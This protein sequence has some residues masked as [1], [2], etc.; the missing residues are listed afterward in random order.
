MTEDT[1]LNSAALAWVEALTARG[2]RLTAHRKGV[3]FDP[4]SAYREMSNEERA[5][6]KAHKHE[7]IALVRA[8]VATRAAG[9]PVQAAAPTPS[10]GAAPTLALAP[11]A[12]CEYCG[13]LASRCAEIRGDVKFLTEH[14]ER[15]DVVE[16]LAKQLAV[17]QKLGWS[18]STL[19]DGVLHYGEP[20]PPR[21]EP[22]D[23]KQVMLRQIG[24]P[25]PDW[26]RR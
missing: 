14:A 15:P 8:G 16:H 2:V 21:A 11:E 24:K 3:M 4:K 17:R 23:A 20:T 6:L 25:L 7:I 12:P 18:A 26:Y 13:A 22:E 9:P 5:T 1:G 10:E 19:R